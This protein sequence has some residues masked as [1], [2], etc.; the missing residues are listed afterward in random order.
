MF[1]CSIVLPY[2]AKYTRHIFLGRTW[3][4]KLS[5][6]QFRQLF[7]FKDLNKLHTNLIM[8]KNFNDLHL[9]SLT[10]QFLD[11]NKEY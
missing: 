4:G 7:P 9:G 11:E 1:L 2:I 3:W 6:P 5:Y 10:I 8:S